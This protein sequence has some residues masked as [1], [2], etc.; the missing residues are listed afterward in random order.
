MNHSMILPTLYIPQDVRQHK[1]HHLRGWLAEEWKVLDQ[2]S[3]HTPFPNVA[4]I[5]LLSPPAST[6]HSS[7]Q[8]AQHLRSC[9]YEHSVCRDERRNAANAELFGLTSCRCVKVRRRGNDTSSIISSAH[10]VHDNFSRGYCS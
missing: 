5:L 1:A 6:L 8:S 7:S 10:I 3:W 9:S 2:A 4:R